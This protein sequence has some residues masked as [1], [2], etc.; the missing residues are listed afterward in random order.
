MIAH[1]SFGLPGLK[2]SYGWQS[3]LAFFGG[4]LN[5]FLILPMI[6]SFGMILLGQAV[7]DW[8]GKRRK[9]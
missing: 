8:A 9:S 4:L 1:L 5:F 2:T 7:A 3:D 6:G